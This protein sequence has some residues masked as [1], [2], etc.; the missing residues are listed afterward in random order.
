MAASY[1]IRFSPIYRD[2]VWGGERLVKKYQKD[3]PKLKVAE[4]W[5]LS[6]RIEGMSQ[7]INGPLKG[8]FLRDLVQSMEEKLLGKDTSFS[9]FPLL[10][11][12]LDAK[13]SLSLQV[14]PNPT[15][16]PLLQAESKNEMWYVLEAEPNAKVY[17]GLKPGVT[18]ENLLK[19]IEE[20][21]VTDVLEVIDVQAGDAIYIPGGCI[22]AICAG[23]LLFEV[24]QNSDTTY[25]IYD[26]GR[27]GRELHIPQAL[28][29]IDWSYRGKKELPEQLSSD[30]SYTLFSVLKTPDFHVERLDV[31]KQWTILNLPETFQIFFCLEG[32]G[33][34]TVDGNREELQLGATYLLPA[35][36]STGEIVGK[37]QLLRVYQ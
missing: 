26:W 32:N 2:Y 22:H 6:D 11:K 19:A 24:Q 36:F 20:G 17:A 15:T 28:A 33:A 29:T 13:E 8:S 27:K 34:I 5:E 23:C 37:C 14:H 7:V 10:V 12:I 21:V 1:P 31:Q 25:R 4:S 30:E 18:Q 16:A 35:A 9:R 3:A